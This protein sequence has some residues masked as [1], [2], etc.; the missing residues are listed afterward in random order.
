[1]TDV[2]TWKIVVYSL[3]LLWV[4][5]TGGVFIAALFASSKGGSHV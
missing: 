4:G 1:M 3:A 2:E 5:A